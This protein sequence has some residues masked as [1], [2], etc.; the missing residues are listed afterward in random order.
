[1]HVLRDS[2]QLRFLQLTSIISKYLLGICCIKVKIFIQ[3]NDF[4]FYGEDAFQV[5]LPR[6]KSCLSGREQNKLANLTLVSN[7]GN[8][9][10]SNSAQNWGI[11]H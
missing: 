9:V 7:N 8:F 11:F 2:L 10:W 3:N 6:Q 4:E 1:M 5:V